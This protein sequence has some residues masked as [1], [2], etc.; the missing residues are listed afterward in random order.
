MLWVCAEVSVEFMAEVSR[1]WRADCRKA[2]EDVFCLHMCDYQLNPFKLETDIPFL[3]QYFVQ[4]LALSIWW[5]PYSRC[6][7]TH[8]VLSAYRCLSIPC[9]TWLP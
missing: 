8:P 7:Q 2:V 6:V 4:R 1:F 3:T 5:G 9:P